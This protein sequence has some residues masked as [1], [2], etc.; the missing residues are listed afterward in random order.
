[1]IEVIFTKFDSEVI[2]HRIVINSFIL[3]YTMENVV[4]SRKSS[5]NQQRINFQG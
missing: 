5:A 2:I 3:M 4:E 1:M